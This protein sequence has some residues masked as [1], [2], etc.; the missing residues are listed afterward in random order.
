MKRKS[1][2]LN[3]VPSNRGRIFRNRN[4][5]SCSPCVLAE[6]MR[7]SACKYPW[8][9]RCVLPSLVESQSPLRRNEIGPVCLTAEEAGCTAADSSSLVGLG[10]AGAAVTFA[11]VYCTSLCATVQVVKTADIN[12]VK[13]NVAFMCLANVP[14]L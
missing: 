4:V 10:L 12:I 5:S 11:L 3:N 1:T 14:L 8:T 2:A 9:C 6:N 13:I 7:S